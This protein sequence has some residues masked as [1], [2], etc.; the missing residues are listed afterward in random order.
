M[1]LSMHMK[2]LRRFLQTLVFFYS[3]EA[4]SV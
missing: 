1:T 2:N 4:Y 3:L